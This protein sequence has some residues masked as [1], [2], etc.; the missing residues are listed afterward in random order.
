[1]HLDD[2]MVYLAA[3]EER[4]HKIGRIKEDKDFR[5]A[6]R[7]QLYQTLITNGALEVFNGFVTRGERFNE[8]FASLVEILKDSLGIKITLDG[9]ECNNEMKEKKTEILQ[10]I[11]DEDNSVTIDV[12]NQDSHMFTDKQIRTLARYILTILW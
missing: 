1:M 6:L 4:W 5:N 7:T 12:L 8:I 11:I 9:V 3:N 2:M 10:K